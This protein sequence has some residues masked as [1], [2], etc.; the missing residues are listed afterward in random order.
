MFKKLYKTTKV[1]QKVDTQEVIKKLEISHKQEMIR[2]LLVWKIL[3]A[4]V[5]AWAVDNTNN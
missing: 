5:I 3:N 2:F 4:E 1:R